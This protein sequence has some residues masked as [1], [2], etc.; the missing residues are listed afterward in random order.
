MSSRTQVVSLGI[1]VADVIG[2][3]VSGMPESGRL[4]LVDE[5]SL[6]PGGCALNVALVLA[7]LDIPVTMVGRIGRDPFG[8]FLLSAVT[9]RGIDT[10]GIRCDDERGTSASMVLVDEGGERRF[11]HY[12]GANAQLNVHDVDMALVTGAA[13]LHVAGSLVM[14]GIDGPPTAGILRQ[15]RAAGVITFLDTAWDETGR[16]LHVLRPCLPHLDYFVPSLVEARALTGVHDPA[17]AAQALLDLG[18]AT[19]AIK[20]G[21]GG[22]L[23]MTADGQQ[24]RSPAFEV[25]VVDTTGAGDAFA[26][27]FIAGVWHGWSLE[28]TAQF[29][30]AV[31]AQCVTGVGALGNIQSYSETLSFLATAVPILQ[32]APK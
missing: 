13:I 10:S 26:A 15:A 19:V 30:N 17:G 27:G 11:I 2:R 23:V 29:A 6:H 18:V 1:M 7:R 24:F 12:I 20:M 25:E 22:C 16:W 3:P 28:K 14:P 8:R 31:G 21:A 5:M 9:E 32:P 4:V